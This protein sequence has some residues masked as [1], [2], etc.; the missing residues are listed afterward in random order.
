MTA[1]RLVRDYSHPPAKVWRALTDPVWMARWLVAARPEGFS[2]RVGTRF[3]FVGKPRLGWNGIVECE[4][5][6]AREPGLLRYSWRSEGGEVMQLSYRLEPHG[7]GTRFSFEQS[8]FKGLGGFLLAKLVMTFI[9]RKMF[10]PRMRALLEA[11]DEATPT[12][13]GPSSAPG[14]VSSH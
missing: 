10:G 3:R 2:T 8:G 9:R 11:Q 6:E 4:L 13:A 5:L 7:D 12:P 1:I 14:I